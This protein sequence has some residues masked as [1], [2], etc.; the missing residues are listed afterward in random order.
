[1]RFWH[2]CGRA[3]Y[4]LRGNWVLM[5]A[6][7]TAC[8]GD[9]SGG[10]ATGNGSGG[11]TGAEAR[12]MEEFFGSSV[13]PRLD[14]CRTCH[15]PGGISDVENGRDFMLGSDRSQD[16]ANL[17]AAWERLGE[18]N[19]TSRILLMASGQETPHS[20][21]VP[22]PVGSDG[23][24]AMDTLLKCFADTAGCAALLAGAGGG[25]VTEL[26]L[27]GSSRA[28]TLWA[29][30][31]EG[32]PDDAVL[33]ADPRALIRPGI[34]TGKAVYY[35]AYYEDCHAVFPEEEQAPKSCGVYRARR[36][37]GQAAFTDTLA[38]GNTSAADFNNTWE[39][40]GL[41]ERPQNFDEMY[42]LRYGL[43]NAPFP[44]PYPLP[45]EDPN[46]TNGGSGKL[47]LGMRQSKDANGKWTGTIGSVACFSCHGGQIGDPAVDP[48]GSLI[49][50]KNLGLGNSNGD[51]VMN[52]NDASALG[53]LGITLPVSLD[54]LNLG[55]DQRG[56]NNAVG[57]FE[58]LF[59]LLDYDSLG[60]NPNA[61][62]LV[63]NSIQPHPTGEAQ[64]TPA[65]WNYGHRP[66][67]F[68]D[69]GQSIDSTRIVMAAGLG[70]LTDVLSLDGK[71]YRNRIEQFDQDLASFFLSLESPVYP[72]AVDTQLAEQG[73]VLF[74]TKDLWAQAG[75][76]GKPHPLGGNGACAGCHGAYSPRFVNDTAYLE[77]PVLEGVAGHISPLDVIGTDS[78]RADHLTPYLREI[79]GT[80]FWGYADGAPGWVSPDDKNLVVELLDDGLPGRPQGACGWERGVIGYQAPP[81]YG[82][83][84][85]APYF[86]NGSV[87]TIEQVLKSSDRPPIWRRKLQTIG[88][89]TGF[90]QSLS[91]AYDYERVGW[92]HDVLACGEI[93]G[94]LLLNCN[95]VNPDAPSITQLIENVLQSTINWGALAT[96]PDLSPGAIDKRLVYDT[97]KI[98]NGNQ[99][100]DFTDALTDQERKAIIEYLKTL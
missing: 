54:L 78:A 79:Y 38:G 52:G 99:G 30:Y 66:R 3:S 23:Y 10:T 9:Y 5:A 44:N 25:T 92:K 4:R 58:L 15:V 29:S 91:R 81:L 43:N 69:A 34:N 48:E 67:K 97:R 36:D 13:Q 28:K 71:A 35:N 98:G 51:T 63:Q 76:A 27:L 50:L 84:A 61:V 24:K 57:G 65:W 89:V 55:V 16:L 41:S 86:H 8:S 42:T 47:P 45:G 100:H 14:F 75:N 93:P 77:T 33:P 31:C 74:H 20:G 1:M 83:W 6:L 37:R 87:P 73:A 26:P 46:L 12:S 85:T 80:T 94:T 2:R 82:T 96:I 64:D 62:K 68:F 32:K 7:L 88:P 11:G 40:W 56:Q 21:G 17:E 90:D 59:M 49:T 72:G 53:G 19:P 18:N 22:W 70:E 60:L 95:P 39:S